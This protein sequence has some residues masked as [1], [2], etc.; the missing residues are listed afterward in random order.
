MYKKLVEYEG[1]QNFPQVECD[2]KVINSD[3]RL[4]IVDNPIAKRLRAGKVNWRE[5]QKVSV[6]IAKYKLDELRIPQIVD[7]IFHWNLEYDDFLGY[8]AGI[9]KLKK[10]SGQVLIV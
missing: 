4:T 5:L 10:F 2:F 7:G 6:Q 9:V 1:L 3:T 8:M